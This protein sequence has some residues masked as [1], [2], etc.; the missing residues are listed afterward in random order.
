MFATGGEPTNGGL[1]FSS[2][3]NLEFDDKGNLWM[4]TEISYQ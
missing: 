3:D 2:P 4:L 1:G